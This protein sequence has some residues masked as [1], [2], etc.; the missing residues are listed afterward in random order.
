MV[1]WSDIDTDLI[2]NVAIGKD[3]VK[4]KYNEGPL[5]FQIP[6]G[7]CTW[8]VSAYKSLNV[9]VANPDFISWWKSLETQL[10]PQEPFSSNMKNNSLRLKIDDAAYIFDENS[11]QVNPEIREGAFRGHEISCLIDIDSTYFFNGNWGLT[12]RVQQLKTLSGPSEKDYVETAVAE[13]SLQKGI[14]AFLTVTDV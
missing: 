2:E 11:K 3:R 4:F 1:L 13:T 5:R 10:C 6:K 14:C 12:I 7:L 8:G 9:E